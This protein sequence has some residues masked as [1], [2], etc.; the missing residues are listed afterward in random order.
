MSLR[1]ERQLDERGSRNAYAINRSELILRIDSITR[2]GFEKKKAFK[3][4]RV[5]DWRRQHGTARGLVSG[6]SH[7]PGANCKARASPSRAL[8]RS[9]AYEAPARRTLAT[10]TPSPYREHPNNNTHGINSLTDDLNRRGLE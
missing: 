6:S 3:E 4:S 10:G 8:L 1:Q 2:V 7:L 9:L 5:R